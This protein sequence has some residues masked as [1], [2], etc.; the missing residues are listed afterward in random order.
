MGFYVVGSSCLYARVPSRFWPSL[1]P[2]VGMNPSSE[3]K[4]SAYLHSNMQDEY[5]H[6]HRCQ[7]L[8]HYT[9]YRDLF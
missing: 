8:Q 7:V 5:N 1:G 3:T 9:Q 2:L 4:N 6:R